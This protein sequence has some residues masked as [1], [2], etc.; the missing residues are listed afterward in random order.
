MGTSCLDTLVGLHNRPC[1][2]PS[3]DF[4]PDWNEST[5]GYFLTDT[6]YGF[7][8]LD[9]VW[10][11]AECGEGSIW[12]V[13]AN[14]RIEAVRDFKSD[15]QQALNAGLEAKVGHW[16]GLI[17]KTDGSFVYRDAFTGVQLRPRRRIRDAAFVVTAIHVGVE[18]AGTYNVHI[19]SNDYAFT[20]VTISVVSPGGQWVR[21]ELATPVRL[22]F[23]VLHEENV[24]YSIELENAGSRVRANKRV[25]CGGAPFWMQYLDAGGFSEAVVDNQKEY[26]GS[27]F[28]GVA[29]E[30]YLDCDKL[31]WLCNLEEMN[32]LDFRD[33]VARCIQFKGAS[34]L[35]AR[36]LESGRVNYWTVLAP[37]AVAAKRK[38][39]QEMYKEYISYLVAN[40]P[41][42]VSGC[43]G[44]IKGQPKMNTI[45]S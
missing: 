19:R 37:E 9:A 13:L 40:M 14:A 21:E 17:G 6:E 31:A 30:G 5:S 39:I 22:P 4:P 41:K 26:N 16:K 23:Y 2:C 15:I 25:C 42:G 45:L 43:W 28:N 18:T 27:Y 24:R 8:I 20:P 32:G 10:A 36:V 12:E 29:V 35:M 38:Q 3:D 7:P 44:C 1:E 11:N 34:K 33:F